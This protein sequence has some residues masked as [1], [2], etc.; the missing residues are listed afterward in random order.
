MIPS[1]SRTFVVF[2]D[3]WGRHV[4]TLQH[5]VTHLLDD[6]YVIWIDSVGMR[7]PRLTIRDLR[8]AA[9]K[10]AALLRGRRS[11]PASDA[12]NAPP[13]SEA[14][15]TGHPAAEGPRPAQVIP[16]LV[17]P[18]HSNPL[19]ARFNKWSLRRMA[20]RALRQAPPGNA[21]VLV[22]ALPTVAYVV[23]ACDETV[24]IY[25]CMD[26]YSA[27]PDTSM[28]TVDLLE[29]RLLE[30]VDAVVATAARLVELKR[31]RSG[32]G[33][34]LPQGCNV[35]HFSTPRAMPGALRDLPRPLIGFAGGFVGGAGQALD[36]ATIRAVAE[37]HP[38]WSIVLVGPL[39]ALQGELRLPN[40]HF[41]GAVP[42]AQLPAYV[43]AFDV[44]LIPYLL[45]EW[46]V[47]IDPLK[48]LEY[49]AAGV[50]VVSS[51]L[52]EAFKYESAITIAALGDPFVD[53]VEGALRR[54]PA[55]R[56]AGKAL[57]AANSWAHRAE[58]FSGI[59]E[60]AM[61]SRV[62]AKQGLSV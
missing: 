29:R 60:E 44:G 47:T 4:S 36:T 5:V 55:E 23:G 62:P 16:P 57:A 21:V 53:A 14:P 32:K 17:L 54:T 34:H 30:R 20:R 51:P 43:Q 22:T 38:E 58:R 52:P 25:F 11:A 42:Y 35:Q 1:P 19:V 50:A 26:N 10:G 48:L 12:G 46:T 28:R 33:Y 7:E 9:G 37:R 39:A 13:P 15:G 40:V 24:S 59:V 45:N 31:A 27:M 3:D 41:T 56:E 49:L 6:H 18:W 2:G 61:A 8:R